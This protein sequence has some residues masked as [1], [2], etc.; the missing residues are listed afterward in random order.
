MAKLTLMVSPT[1]APTWKLALPK[2]PSRSL[3]PLKEVWLPIRSISARRCCTSES[4]AARSEA[5]YV[6][7]AD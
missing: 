1:L 5:E 7:L 4:S 6:E 3:V 2:L